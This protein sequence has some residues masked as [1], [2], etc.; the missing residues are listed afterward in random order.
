MEIA[1]PY[2]MFLGDVPDDLAAKTAHGSC[3][4]QA[5]GPTSRS[6]T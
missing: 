5:A 1:A 4:S 3:A 6:R 2:L